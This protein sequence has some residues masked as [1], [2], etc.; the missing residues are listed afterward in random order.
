LQDAA[1]ILKK[2]PFQS[3]TLPLISMSGWVWTPGKPIKWSGEL[4]LFHMVS[5]KEVKVCVLCTPD[6]EKEAKGCRG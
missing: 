3:L 2:L 5:G 6:K 1:E 4:L